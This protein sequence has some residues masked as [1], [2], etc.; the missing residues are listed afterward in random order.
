MKGLVCCYSSFPTESA[1]Q[2]RKN[3][4]PK[5]RNC[6]RGGGTSRTESRCQQEKECEWRICESEKKPKRRGGILFLVGSRVL[7][8]TYKALPA[9]ASHGWVYRCPGASPSCQPRTEMRRRSRSDSPW[10]SIGWACQRCHPLV[11]S[12]GRREDEKMSGGGGGEKEEFNQIPAHVLIST[13][14]HR[15]GGGCGSCV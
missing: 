1:P 7:W 11:S 9:R 13:L 4:P 6:N 12:G 2:E 15:R 8:Y 5:L 14:L 3:I 10:K